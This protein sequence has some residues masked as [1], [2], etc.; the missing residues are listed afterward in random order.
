MTG[1]IRL[2]EWRKGFRDLRLPLFREYQEKDD[3]P[4]LSIQAV[5]ERRFGGKLPVVVRSQLHLVRNLG[6]VSKRA[7]CVLQC[8]VL[9]LREAFFFSLR[10]RFLPV[11]FWSIGASIVMLISTIAWYAAS[12]ALSWIH[13]PLKKDDSSHQTDDSA[14]SA[15]S[16]N[17]RPESPPEKSP[18][19]EQSNLRQRAKRST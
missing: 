16:T 2:K 18:Q 9:G 15:E 14:D 4:L 17:L 6:T 13:P 1:K 19:T 11:R 10:P 8:D 3:K 12:K 7:F 5:L